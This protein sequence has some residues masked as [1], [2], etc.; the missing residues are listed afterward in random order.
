MEEIK[1]FIIE[2]RSKK[3]STSREGEGERGKD[4][5]YKQKEREE[6][7]LICYYLKTHSTSISLEVE[8]CDQNLH[9]S[10]FKAR[11]IFF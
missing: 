6:N 1:S 8:R 7:R 2:Q 5:K 9:S 10:P 11:I 3:T 4:N